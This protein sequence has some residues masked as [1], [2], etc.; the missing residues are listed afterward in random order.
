VR[1]LASILALS[2]ITAVASAFTPE[3]LAGPWCYSHYEAGG[4]RETQNINYIFHEDGTLLYQNNPQTPVEKPGTYTME[5]DT[6]KIK[7]TFM[8]FDFKLKSKSDNQFVLDA[9]GD[10]VFVRGECQ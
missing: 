3:Y 9:F 1:K 5:G 8:M 2:A 10:H 6:I 7:P 4:E